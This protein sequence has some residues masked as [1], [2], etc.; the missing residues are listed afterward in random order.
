MNEILGMFHGLANGFG[1]A[2]SFTNLLFALIGAVLGTIVGILP[3]L[4]PAATISLLL[5]LSF[6]I[7]SPVTSIIMMAGIFWSH[8]WRIDHLNS[9]QHPW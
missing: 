5:P 1:I 9:G 7:G 8:V 6:K 4:G 3:G 2:F